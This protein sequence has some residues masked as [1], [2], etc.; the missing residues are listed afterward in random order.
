MIVVADI[1][2]NQP[3]KITLTDVPFSMKDV[4]NK[5][6]GLRWDKS[7]R[8]NTWRMPLGWANYLSLFSTFESSLRLG[9]ALMEWVEYE[10][11]Y[12]ISPALY[13]RE[14]EDAPGLESLYPFQ[15]VGVQF[16]KTA[17][18][19]LCAD[20]MGLGKTRQAIAT[21][22]A[23][24]QDGKDPFPCLVV[25]PN[26]TKIGWKREF[27]AVW[28]GLTVT[29]V[30]GTATQ[31]RKQLSTG[32]HVVILNWEAVKGH[33]RLAPYGSVA[34]R[35]CREC[36]GNTDKVTPASCHTHIKELNTINF[37]SVIC[38]EIHKMKDGASQQSRAVKYASGDADIRIGLSG[39]PIANSPVDLW[40]ILNWISPGEYPSKTQFIDRMVDESKDIHGYTT[41]LGIRPS[42]K[43]EFF[44][45][46]DPRMIRRT[47]EQVLPWLPK[48]TFERR[49]LEMK[50]NQKKAYIQMRDTMIA[51][52]ENSDNLVVTNPMVKIGR[53]LQFASSYAEAE[54]TM[55][56]DEKTGEL[57]PHTEV[58]LIEPSN[59]IDAFLGDLPDFG[60]SQLVVFAPS[61]QLINLLSARM[62][63]EDMPH[64]L[65]TGAIP[66]DERQQFMDRFQDGK[67]QWILCTT[68]AGGTGLTLTAADTAVYLQRPWSMIESNQADDRIYRIGSER[69][70]KIT[71]VDYVSTGTVDEA[72][73]EKLLKKENMSQEI[74]RDK[75]NFV[76]FVKGNL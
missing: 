48:V 3:K 33:S 4:C 46:L 32:A 47:K 30:S 37:K 11:T 50:P 57:K 16:L 67:L 62:E 36:G 45:G 61:R 51:E 65:V 52:L 76:D 38:D 29:V 18:Q 7:V 5:V 40:S 31:R 10:T 72:V 13:W 1:D 54:V 8:G 66:E 44:Q 21:L 35:R 42:M 20:D 63:K 69:H 74:L 59:K 60:D 15:R 53:L 2:P 9:P 68:G 70:D 24:Y 17:G 55:V 73:I 14:Q 26:S 19:A 71:I 56:L 23:H 75:K 34:L 25:A 6:P 22:M 39:T 27:E 64:G 28:P 12:R 41:Y 58:T 49:D 43:Q